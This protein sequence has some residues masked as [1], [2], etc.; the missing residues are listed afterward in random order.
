MSEKHLV[1]SNFDAQT[2][3]DITP[4]SAGWEYLSFR[5]LQ[6]KSGETYSHNTEQT[7]LAL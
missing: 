7:E 6:L 4:E 1:H 2:I 5:I 3:M